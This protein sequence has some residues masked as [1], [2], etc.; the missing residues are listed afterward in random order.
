MPKRPLDLPVV[1]DVDVLIKHIDVLEPHDPAKQRG[2]RETRLAIDVGPHGDAQRIV[3][4][5]NLAQID[6][7]RFAHRAFQN[8]HRLRL[9][10]HRR[11]HAGLGLIEH[12]GGAVLQ[13]VV[14]HVAPHGDGGAMEH[15]VHMDRTVVAHVL[16]VGPFRLHIAALIEIAFQRHLGVGRHQDVVGETFDDGSRLA[17]KR[18][19]QG[20]LVAGLARGRGKH[21]ERMRTRP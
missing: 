19:H 3:A 17:A 6:R 7:H 9:S 16:A 10:A 4:A 1:V 5:G 8:L 13:R 11:D 21:I 20:Q 12:E 2:N 18:G 14:Q 15:R